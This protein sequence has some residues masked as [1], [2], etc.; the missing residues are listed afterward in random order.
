MSRLGVTAFRFGQRELIDAVLAGEDA[1][2]ILPTGSGKSL[3]Y[4]LPALLV[5]KPVVVVSPLIALMKDQCDHLARVRIDAA[6]LDS[7]R[8]PKSVRLIED[9]VARGARPI[10]YVTPERFATDACTAMLRA[11]G[12]SLIA[13]D[14]AHCVSQW[15]HDFRPAYLRI[16][17]RAAMLAGPDGRRPPI[18]ALT[19]TATRETERDIVTALGLRAP[20]TVRAS[21]LRPNLGFE[22]V[23]TVNEMSKEAALMNVLD[24]TRGESGIVYAAT[25]KAVDALYGWLA[26]AGVPVARYHGQMRPDDREKSRGCFMRGEVSLMIATKAF[27]MGIDKP[28]VRFVVHAQFPDSLESYVQEAGRA[29]R[30]GA[31]A[32]CVLLYRLEDR[33][34]QTFFLARK[35][36]AR[37]DIERVC[38]ALGTDAR[39]APSVAAATGIPMR[40]VAAVLAHLGPE[41]GAGAAAA[42]LVER[43]AALA[44]RDRARLDAMAHYAEQTGCRVTAIG[45][46]FGE[47]TTACGDCDACAGLG[48]TGSRRSTRSHT[49]NAV[50]RCI[51]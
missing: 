32:R 1:L 27:G 40:R 20:R 33:R 45:T 17:E 3:T 13:V 34:V 11:R 21:V 42:A 14:E 23:R 16:A 39:D 2:G 4:E 24:E 9:Q 25:V 49:A 26:A 46:Y 30:D 41:G 35:Y 10:L 37:A 18:L 50:L 12:V 48:C 38:A 51:A 7:T 6:E 5:D 47:E 8:S 43:F 29:G 22:V 19:A 36:P 28:D 31:P 15:G 44:K